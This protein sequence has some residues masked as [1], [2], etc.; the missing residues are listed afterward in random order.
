MNNEQTDALQHAKLSPSSADR[1][2]TC[3][4][5]V[6]LAEKI[7]QDP[8]AING[9][10]LYGSAAHYV[11]E[12][13]LKAET[14]AQD[15]HDF[16]YWQDRKTHN[17][18][19]SQEMPKDVAVK[20]LCRVDDEMVEGVQAYLDFVRSIKGELLVEQR[21]DLTQWIPEGFGTSDAVILTDDGVCHVID[22][23]FGKGIKVYAEKNRQAMIYA[24]GA[25]AE[26]EF[27]YEPH[28]YRVTIVQ[29]RLDHI[30]SYDVPLDQLLT[31]ADTVKTAADTLAS[32]KTCF[33]PSDKA[34][35]WCPA[36]P[37][38]PALK[39]HALSVAKADFIEA[40][41]ENAEA[42]TGDSS[43]LENVPYEVVNEKR[44]D[45][46]SSDDLADMGLL[47]NDE[48]ATLLPHLDVLIS[49][50]KSVQGYALDEL[51][52]GRDVPNHKLVEGR[53]IRK[54]AD[55]KATEE[56]F[57]K[58]RSIKTED[59]YT[60]KFISPAQAEKVLGKD[61]K[62]L[63]G[64]IVKPEGKPTLAIASDKRPALKSDIENDY[65]DGITAEGDS[66]FD[67]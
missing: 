50:A 5:S 48:I 6:A 66:M 52:A 11:A 40:D 16:W 4:G 39:N 34:C 53:S 59:I 1:W 19:I 14:H 46:I 35:Q 23:K 25:M 28:T 30:D 10:A 21:F 8:D 33:N 67:D 47:S 51:K 58:A 2:M 27:M 54:W 20:F 22:L 42:G 17:D 43:V 26:Y 3:S 12:L 62:L 18:M 36:K 9:Y 57:K 60:K 56:K 37:V 65:D 45:T 31:F 7:V 41:Q 63:K 44:A 32:G 55:P 29:P 13:C 38:C 61:H 15:Y 49:W 64:L 24:M